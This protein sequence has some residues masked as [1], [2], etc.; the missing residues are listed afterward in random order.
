[1][2]EK[3]ETGLSEHQGSLLLGCPSPRTPRG[4]DPDGELRLAAGLSLL[5]REGHPAGCEEVCV[6]TSG[7]GWPGKEGR[8]PSQ[9]GAAP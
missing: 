5:C 2:N 7:H 6:V 1:M 8:P 4:A 9:C 3:K